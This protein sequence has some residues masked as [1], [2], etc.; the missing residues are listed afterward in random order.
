MKQLIFRFLIASF[1]LAAVAG[2]DKFLDRMPDNRAEIDTQAKIRA[3]L[4]SAYP[5]TDY[6]LITEFMSDNVDDY[7]KNNPNTDRFIDQVY[8]WDD[9][10]E[11]DNED[12]ESLWGSSYIAI[13]ASNQAL[14]A[15][16]EL[17]GVEQTG[18]YAEM[19]E[20]RLC[21]AYNMFILA[22][23]FCK[24]YD[25][26]TAGQALGIPYPEKPETQ[27]N[28]QYERGTLREVYEKIDAD[29]TAALPYISD[30]YYTVPKYHFNTKAAY[31]F[32][33]RFYLYYEQY[34]KSLEYANKVLG[35]QPKTMLRDWQYQAGMTQSYDPI[36]E[37]YIDASL[38]C[39]L[40]L[41]TAYSKMGLAFGPYMI[42]SKYAHGEYLANRETGIAIT[43]LWGGSND[44]Y[45][46]DMKIYS[47]TNLDKTIF[48][49]LPFLFEYTDPV[50]QIGYYRTVYP[51]LSGDMVLLERA[52]V[53]TILGNYDAAVDDIN[54]WIGNIAI[55]PA[56][57]TKESIQAYFNNIGYCEWNNATPKKHLNPTAAV[58]LGEE[59]GMKES[60]LQCVLALTRVESLG[61]GLRWFYIKRYGIEIDRRV[62]NAAGRPEKK[63]DTLLKD[64][65]RRAV[66][67]PPKVRDANLQG[68]PRNS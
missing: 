2:C 12:P 54:T 62:I 65:E 48:W 57:L 25:P 22:N 60:L 34:A 50:A 47:A 13:A 28:P 7:G 1:A 8:A 35:T 58:Q 56:V 6:M 40:L 51:A 36:V 43:S 46:S 59:G 18:M 38:N 19:A 23:V 64:D 29:I 31:A 52:E 53:N 17:G 33:A 32:A 14:Q 30:T 10:T 15:I 3:L 39:N 16:E 41:M 61:Q 68:N 4:T 55:S 45:Y 42:Y 27:L 44:T 49:K 26:A 67:I 66:Q 9:V 63:T 37:H 24:A 20:A 5:S 21:R 11:T